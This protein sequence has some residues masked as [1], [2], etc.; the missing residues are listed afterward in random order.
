MTIKCF[1]RVL[2]RQTSFSSSG[3]S[4]DNSDANLP[5]PYCRICCCCCY[6][7]WW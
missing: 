5:C 3:Q 2:V 6:S 7:S 4:E 1:C